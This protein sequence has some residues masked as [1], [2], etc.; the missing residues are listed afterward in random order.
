MI[1]KVRTICFDCH[2]KCG[3]I[4]TVDTDKNAIVRV[5]GDP[6]HGVSEGILCVKAFSAQEIHAHPDRLEVPDAAQDLE[7]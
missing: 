3:V 5:E 2:S 7:H 4:L 6:N 1:K